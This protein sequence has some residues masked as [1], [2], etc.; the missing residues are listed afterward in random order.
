MVGVHPVPKQ[1]PSAFW[2]AVSFMLIKAADK[3]TP[4]AELHFKYQYA[5]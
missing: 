3:S 1:L 5:D 4:V 2:L